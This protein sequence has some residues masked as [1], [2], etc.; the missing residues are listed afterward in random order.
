MKL[1]DFGPAANSK[2]VRMFISEKGLE[3]PVVE[4]NVRDD[5]QFKEPF[6]SMNPFHCVP[7]LELDDGTVIDETVAICR[8]I[9]EM[10][11]EPALMG[12]DA[13]D[14]AHVESRQRHM[15]W[16]GLLPAMEAFR[17]SFPGFATRGLGGN[18]GEVSAIAE[19]AERG[20]ASLGRFYQRLDGEL[21]GCE[22]V[23]GDTF[24]IA[25]I[26]ALCTIDFAAGAARVGIP[27]ACINVKR[28]HEAVSMRDSAKA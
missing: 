7:F 21:A 13:V 6:N 3:V 2:R 24:S 28:W 8:Y 14:K 25:D 5:A 27:D 22:F 19:L 26:T 18:V 9:E 15:E 16:D 11:P 23:A 20:K 10:H 1:Y 4:L 17:N 12:T